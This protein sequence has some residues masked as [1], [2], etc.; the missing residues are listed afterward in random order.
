MKFFRSPGFWYSTGIVLALF[1]GWAAVDVNPRQAQAGGVS[2]GPSVPVTATVATL[3]T[4]S[5]AADL[6]NRRLCGVYIPAGMEG[7]TITFTVGNALAGTYVPL[8]DKTGAAYSITLTTAIAQYLP[9]DSDIFDGIQ[10]IKV[11]V[12]AQTGEIIFTLFTR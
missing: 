7:T 10:F 9:V 3:G 2:L 6:G 5:G 8:R 1:V 12:A 11:V 4:T